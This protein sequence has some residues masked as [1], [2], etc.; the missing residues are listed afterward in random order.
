MGPTRERSE[1]SSCKGEPDLSVSDADSPST[2][3]LKRS[4]SDPWT[5]DVAAGDDAAPEGFLVALPLALALFALRLLTCPRVLNWPP[6]PPSRCDTLPSAFLADPE[7]FALLGEALPFLRWLSWP[8]EATAATV[9][10]DSRSE[11]APAL[12]FDMLPDGAG[13]G[14]S[15]RVGAADGGSGNVSLLAALSFLTP[16]ANLSPRGDW[17]A[18]IGAGGW[19]GPQREDAR[20]ELELVDNSGMN[21]KA[22]Y[23]Y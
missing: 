2:T 4:R 18:C 5:E 19:T 12:R 11:E 22:A 7:G 3:T 6:L 1:S 14:P 23:E 21:E 10:T 15:P 13:G 17:D 8:A 20:G 16:L 9:L